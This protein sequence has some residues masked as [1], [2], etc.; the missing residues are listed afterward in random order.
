MFLPGGMADM[1]RLGYRIL[2]LR[3]CTTGRENKESVGTLRATEEAI[4]TVEQN[5]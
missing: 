3:D 4:R 5:C 1:A 2:L